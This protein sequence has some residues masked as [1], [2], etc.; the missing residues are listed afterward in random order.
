MARRVHAI[1]FL[2]II[3]MAV[4]A[5]LTVALALPGNPAGDRSRSFHWR[6]VALRGGSLFLPWGKAIFLQA[7]V[8]LFAWDRNAAGRFS[9]KG[10]RAC[11]EG[12]GDTWCNCSG[13]TGFEFGRESGVDDLDAA[14]MEYLL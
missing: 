4:L 5:P 3:A 12:Q 7:I 9:R 8:R 10:I 2:L 11:G 1:A 14:P 13:V 6:L